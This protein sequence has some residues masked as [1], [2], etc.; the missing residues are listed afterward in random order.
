MGDGADT[1]RD[2]EVSQVERIAGERVRPF[3]IEVRRNQAL[4]LPGGAIG[5]DAEDPGT[6]S[7]SEDAEGEADRHERRMV[8]AAGPRKGEDGE[9]KQEDG[10][11]RTPAE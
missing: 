5:H 10:R 11:E 2:E 9:G 4:V 8:P 7:L 1:E 3:G 6:Q